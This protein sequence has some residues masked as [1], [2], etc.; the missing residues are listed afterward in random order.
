[1]ATRTITIIEAV[2]DWLLLVGGEYA[3]YE[4]HHELR[5]DGA[6]GGLKAP[7]DHF[8]FRFLRS[9]TEWTQAENNSDVASTYNSTGDYYMGFDR[10]L[11]I[12][13]HSQHGL[14]VLEAVVVSMSHPAVNDILSAVGLV[15]KG[16][17]GIENET[18]GDDTKVDHLYAITLGCRKNTHFTVTRDNQI[19]TSYNVTGTLTLPDDVSTLDITCTD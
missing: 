19:W 2:R 6:P 17:T 4:A 11:R 10:E 8:V 7:D 18:T 12:E 3:I 16:T 5:P 15:I 14:E 1:M 9:S 13:C